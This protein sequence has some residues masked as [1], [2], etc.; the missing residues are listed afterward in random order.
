MRRGVIAVAVIMLLLITAVGFLWSSASRAVMAQV[1]DTVVEELSKA[2]GTPVSVDK[3]EIASYNQIVLYHT[4]VMDKENRAIF[5]SEKITVVY[6]PIGIL[7]GKTSTDVIR[8]IAVSEPEL[9]LIQSAAGRWNVEDLLQKE[10]ERKQVTFKGKISFERGQV[11]IAKPAGQ[12]D[13]E[14]VKGTLD[15]GQE[16]SVKTVLSGLYGETALEA[17]GT[18][19]TAGN[20]VLNL[21]AEDLPLVSCQALLPETLAVQL[22]EGEAKS[23][24]LVI[25][26]ENGQISYAGEADVSQ[27]GFN[28]QDVPV[29]N[30]N[31]LVTFDNDNVH[32]YRANGSVA[33]QQLAAN[34]LISLSGAAPQFNLDISSTGFSPEALRP[35]FIV[36][37][38]LAFTAH[39][40]G[41]LDYP[42]I[43]GNFALAQGQVSDY[44]L[45]QAEAKL[46]LAG[47]KLE[48]QD[49]SANGLDGEIKAVALV[50]LRENGYSLRLQGSHINSAYVE[51]VASYLSGS[52]DV[53]L[54]ISQPGVGKD[55]IL[56]GTAAMGTGM[57][58]GVPFDALT[59][60]FYKKNNDITLDYV[61]VKNGQGSVNAYGDIK[62]DRIKLT[63]RGQSVSLADVSRAVNG[64]NV[65]GTADF[66]GQVEGTIQDPLVALDFTAR[67]GQAFYQP[68]ATAQGHI[69][70]TSEK[71]DLDHFELV[72]GQTVHKVHGSVG[73]RGDKEL[74]IAISSRQ[75]RAE[76]LVQL[77][78]PG[79][80]LTGNVDNDVVLTG[81]L[82]NINAV[83]KMQL[84]DGSFRGYLLAKA[85]GSY[86]RTN[87]TTYIHNFA[88]QS[89]LAALNFD[90]KIGAN[91][92]FDLKVTAQDMDLATMR[93]NLPYPASGK[94]NFNGQLQGVPERPV[95]YG[96]LSSRSILF[97]GQ[98][99]T[100]V[101]GRLKV[102]GSQINIIHLG[103]KENNGN[104][105]F[106]GGMNLM[107][108]AVNGTLNV[109]N[110]ELAGLLPILNVK[111]SGIAGRLNGYIGVTGTTSNPSISV[112]GGLTQ[113]K[114][115][116]YPLENVDID[117][118][119]D[120]NVVTVNRFE[121]KQGQGV[122]AIRGRADL[123]GPL[124]L[125]IGGR[126]IDAGLLTAWLDSTIET[127][128]KM[129][130]AA[131][132]SGSMDSPKANVSL[133]ITQGGV[134]NATFD[135]LY[136]LF[137]L[138][139]GSINVN[140]L[141]LK[142]GPYRASAYGIIPY[143]ALN[144]SG[145]SQASE[146]D[147]MNLKVSLD[148]ANLSILPV[149]TNEV[150]WATGQTKGEVV[151][152]GTLA[153]P[154]LSG[155]IQVQDGTIKLKALGD[156]IQKVGVDIRFEG[157][158]INVKA[159]EGHTGS[160]SVKLSGGAAL[161]GLSLEDYNL[162]LAIDRFNINNKYFKGPVNGTMALKVNNGKPYLTGKLVFENDTIDIPGIPELS[163]SDLDVG[164]DV[165]V[166]A[167]QKVRLYNAYLYDI[168]TAG[169]VKFSGS[170]QKPD[171]SGHFTA[172]RGTVSY[173]RTQFKL[174]SGSAQFTQFGSFEPMIKLDAQTKLSDTTVKL[175]LNGPVSNMNMK[176]TSE[177]EMSEQE[178][179]SLLT[180]RSR[181]FEKQKAGGADTGLGRDE[182][183][184]LLDAGLQMR[185]V[186][187]MESTIREA[188]NL[189][190]FRLVRDTLSSDGKEI[191]ADRE[192]YNIEIG[193]YVTD[194]LFLNYTMGLGHE[195]RTMG[196]RYDL[197]R[198]YSITG[199]IDEKN[200]AQYGVEAR[201]T[202]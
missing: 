101:S 21:H 56:Q 71:V 90:G 175:N 110:G 10:E 154:V 172:I 91:E 141:M 104:F 183:V 51:E 156:P 185:F 188:L 4:T 180:L 3:I 147:Q 48:V 151:I 112:T 167:G 33:G 133:E 67:D 16:P 97:N 13:F 171:V 73:L 145:L 139:H 53:D 187:A 82:D 94:I 81:P 102:D 59:T 23:I 115:K 39:L 158:K 86:E 58:S 109:E 165:E 14:Q 49:F 6:D 93:L 98:E 146:A 144:R 177:P 30:V 143:K 182:L 100:D 193:K 108:G 166:V 126:N 195:E 17:N 38:P 76:N 118:S 155:S 2:L 84:T 95:F 169:K 31:G 27:V 92:E 130:F 87:G 32:L 150:S 135:A 11:L 189:D 29:R 5:D 37:G 157:D 72:S 45:T 121:A 44:A 18:V 124:D 117:L 190:E 68:F 140:Q 41:T 179:L 66:S 106:A 152:G 28:F 20:G 36:R 149:L 186:S 75:A 62:E 119:L 64:L 50:D 127:T 12:W 78:L 132:V 129:N 181:Y 199:A 162:N 9:R 200:R 63:L 196:A 131:Q 111:A 83:G 174:N 114:I 202:F 178:I 57:L 161:K 148:E 47:T 159:I 54:Y 138:D 34:G 26:K 122:L 1:Q 125:Q 52:G 99:I 77:L 116:N 184:G 201:F 107:S 105:A 43:D 42:I 65:T 194:R 22:E 19:T 153:A 35:D 120:N 170:T 197:S 136:G 79:E 80:K 160:G 88:V 70:I 103:F 173:L 74:N 15:F 164:L 96:D 163:S 198:R 123:S 61:S 192:V 89:L 176:L 55:M 24:D 46:H 168:W 137:I 69:A 191:P 128:G 85:G 134:A 113:G 40:S 25:K 7:R 142:K 60:S 8:E